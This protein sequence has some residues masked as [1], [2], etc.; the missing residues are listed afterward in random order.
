MDTKPG[1]IGGS[2][3]IWTF[4]G[5]GVTGAGV[6]GVWPTEV[7]EFDAS[8][9]LFY[10]SHFFGIGLDEENQSEMHDERISAWLVKVLTD[11][12]LIPA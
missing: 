11:C 12:K 9:G 3:S 7:Y 8:E 6:A 4:H 1:E 2:L 10:E 5:C